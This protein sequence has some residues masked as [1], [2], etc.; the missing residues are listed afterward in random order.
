MKY[1]AKIYAHGTQ[2]YLKVQDL[3]KNAQLGA[4]IVTI[5]DDEK[6][7][8]M[9]LREHPDVGPGADLFTKVIDAVFVPTMKQA[10]ADYDPKSGK[11]FMPEMPTAHYHSDDAINA[12]DH[13]K[14]WFMCHFVF[15]DE[16]R[17][18]Y[19]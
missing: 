16:Q 13:S 9:V 18:D 12:D 1:Y 10:Q 2:N 4:L 14:D 11:P 8:V 5:A 6:N 7:M 19:R 3:L 17:G 15:G